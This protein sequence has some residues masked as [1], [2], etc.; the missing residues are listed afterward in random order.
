MTNDYFQIM[1]MR[2]QIDKSKL[3]LCG[4]NDIAKDIEEVMKVLKSQQSEIERLKSQLND[5]WIEKC[6]SRTAQIFSH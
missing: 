1:L 6:D 5:G 4:Y 3:Y 2:L